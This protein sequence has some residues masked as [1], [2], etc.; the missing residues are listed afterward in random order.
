MHILNVFGEKN[1]WFEAIGQVLH[2]LESESLVNLETYTVL[3]RVSFS[4]MAT[5]N[6]NL[7]TNK[8]SV[9]KREV[10]TLGNVLYIFVGYVIC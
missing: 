1:D 5:R 8:K 3:Y 6:G 2:Y 9:T 7:P 10:L 4:I